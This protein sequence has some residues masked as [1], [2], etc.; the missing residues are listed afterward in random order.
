MSLISRYS[1][2]KDYRRCPKAYEYKWIRNLQ[3]RKPAAP[4]LRGTILHELLD[5]RALAKYK[6]LATNDI[7]ARYHK[8]FGALFKEEREIYGDDFLGDIRRIYEGYDT[9]YRD[10]GWVYEESEVLIETELT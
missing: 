6:P 5:A 8:Q 9:L 4:L 7:L 10:D 2:V 1:M 3:K